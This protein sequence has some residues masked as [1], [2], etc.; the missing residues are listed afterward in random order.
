M[1]YIVNVLFRLAHS[2]CSF[3][4]DKITASFLTVRC[5]KPVWCIKYAFRCSTINFFF[6]LYAFFNLSI[7]F[8]KRMRI[9]LSERTKVNQHFLTILLTL[10]NP[11]WMFILFFVQLRKRGRDRAGRRTASF[12]TTSPPSQSDSSLLLLA[13]IAPLPLPLN[14]LKQYNRHEVSQLLQVYV[15]LWKTCKY[16]CVNIHSCGPSS[17]WTSFLN[18]HRVSGVCFIT[19][20][21]RVRIWNKVTAE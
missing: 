21:F 9:N 20:H 18:R 12:H 6:P 1:P 4:R 2:C 19:L 11:Q 14:Q 10:R 7:N 8:K 13:C 17:S 15:C 3:T 16:W 5:P